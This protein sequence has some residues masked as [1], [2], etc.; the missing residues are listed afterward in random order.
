[1]A[2]DWPANE[3]EELHQ[4]LKAKLPGDADMASVVLLAA[5]SRPWEHVAAH[6]GPIA[7]AKG[8][9][10]HKKADLLEAEKLDGKLRSRLVYQSSL[11]E[12]CAE[13]LP[14]ARRLH[15]QKLEKDAARRRL[16]PDGLPMT[17][18]PLPT[19]LAASFDGPAPRGANLLFPD[20]KT[21]RIRDP[22]SERWL[23]PDEWPYLDRYVLSPSGARWVNEAWFRSLRPPTRAPEPEVAVLIR[24]AQVLSDK[25]RQAANDFAANLGPPSQ[26]EHLAQMVDAAWTAALGF[27]KEVTLVSMEFVDAVFAAA[28]I[29]I[30][31]PE[32]DRSLPH[33]GRRARDIFAKS[34]PDYALRLEVE[35]LGQVVDAWMQPTRA[36]VPRWGPTQKLLVALHNPVGADEEVVVPTVASLEKMWKKHHAARHPEA[37]GA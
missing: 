13:M 23:S 14:D 4:Y 28:R 22:A 9:L 8:I 11:S 19:T 20:S 15:A 30:W 31:T 32:L 7:Y 10:E 27:D 5:L 29:A 18:L 1:M 6:G 37:V 24:R 3:A 2:T 12:A 26:R 34:H 25:L 16:D 21:G 33:L 17:T 36:G 35:A